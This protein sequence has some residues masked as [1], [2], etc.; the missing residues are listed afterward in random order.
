MEILCGWLTIKNENKNKLGTTQ[1]RN[2]AFTWFRRKMLMISTKI[3]TNYKPICLV[4]MGVFSLIETHILTILHLFLSKKQRSLLY[5]INENA[6]ISAE[7]ITSKCW[8]RIY[9]D[10][11]VQCL[12]Q[13]SQTKLRWKSPQVWHS[14]TNRILSRCLHAFIASIFAIPGCGSWPCS[15]TKISTVEDETARHYLI[16][17]RRS[18]FGPQ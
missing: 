6:L 9:I 7:K 8:K 3:S 15:I 18:G 2:G 4:N 16:I 14:W 1:F 13:L 11:K 5:R 12:K 17:I 10:E